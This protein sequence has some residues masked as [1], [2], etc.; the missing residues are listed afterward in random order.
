M[1]V[2]SPIMSRWVTEGEAVP[3]ARERP[4]TIA[5]A[6]ILIA[7]TAAGLALT[8]RGPMEWLNWEPGQWFWKVGRFLQGPATLFGVTMS[9]GLIVIRLRR[10]RPRIIR[11]MRQPGMAAACAVVVATVAAVVWWTAFDLFT[12]GGWSTKESIARISRLQGETVGPTVATVW[13]GLWLA[14]RWRPEKSWIDSSGQ[15]LGLLFLISLPFSRPFAMWS[16]TALRFL[17]WVR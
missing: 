8:R 6:M 12:E 2:E 15:A 14:G 11:V 17:G 4:F 9:L 16:I 13:L 1:L 5:D 7:A 3:Q 10:P